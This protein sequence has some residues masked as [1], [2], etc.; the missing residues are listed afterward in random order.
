MFGYTHIRVVSVRIIETN[1]NFEEVFKPLFVFDS[2]LSGVM[3]KGL[4]LSSE[5]E[6]RLRSLA[7][8]QEIVSS[9][10]SETY[11]SSMITAYYRQ[12]AHVVINIPFTS[13]FV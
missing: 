5:Q 7:E 10:E 13:S 2:L 12:K 11:V 9:M 6:Q 1:K 3:I 8:K 4:I